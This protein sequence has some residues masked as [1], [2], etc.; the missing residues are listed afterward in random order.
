MK[1]FTWDIELPLVWGI[2][3]GQ[4]PDMHRYMV[5]CPKAQ[6]SGHSRQNHSAHLGRVTLQLLHLHDDLWVH[7]LLGSTRRFNWKLG[8]HLTA[9]VIYHRR[10]HFWNSGWSACRILHQ[11]HHIRW[12][13]SGHSDGYLHLRYLHHCLIQ[14][15]QNI[16]HHINHSLLALHERKC[17]DLALWSNCIICWLL[18]G[19]P[20]LCG[21]N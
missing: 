5:L 3:V 16:L 11:T 2:N 20:W 15:N 1:Y 19:L 9:A 4:H 13:S 6:K 14:L 10:G 8:L 21:L 18:L 12:S 7:H 17:Q